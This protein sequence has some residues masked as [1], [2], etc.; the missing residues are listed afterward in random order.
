MEK[1]SFKAPILKFESDLWSFYLAIPKE[2]GNHF[3]VGDDRRVKC[4]INNAKPIHSALMPKG[5]V[6]SIYVKKDFLK[7][8]LL[9]EGDEVDVLL[10]KDTSEYGIPLPESF[11]VLLDQD[12]EGSLYFHELTKGK[13][14]SLIHI[15]GKVKNVDSQLAKGLAIMHH[16]KE[17]KGELDFKRL[18]VLIKEYNNRK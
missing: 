16:L 3:I 2:I 5:D 7:K 8:H 14:R 17:T 15:V 4:T 18:N 1:K 9:E 13:Q 10:E 6:Y 11:Q 12:E